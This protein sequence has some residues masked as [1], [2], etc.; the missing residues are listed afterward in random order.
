MN[1]PEPS[2]PWSRERVEEFLTMTTIPVRLSCRTPADDLWMLSLWYEWDAEQSELRCA[3]S[4]DADVV[5]F[6]RA[7]DDVAFEISTNDP[8]Y[9]GVRG[10]GTTT[11]EADEQKTVLRRLIGRYLGDDD[12]PLAERLLSP[13]RD[14][15]TIRIRPTKLHTWDYASRMSSSK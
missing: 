14:E 1:G 5:R 10:R 9:R 6:L 7:Y 4:A 8:P 13:E 12:T 11:V 3:T 15:V 2:G